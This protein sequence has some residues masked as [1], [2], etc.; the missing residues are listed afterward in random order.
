MNETLPAL[1]EPQHRGPSGTGDYFNGYTA[2]QMRAYA[3]AAIAAAH[4]QAEYIIGAFERGADPADY[5]RDIAEFRSAHAQQPAPLTDAYDAVCA[6]IVGRYIVEQRRGGGFWPYC[7][8]AVGGTMELFIG[9]KTKCEEV[10]A[11]LQ[12]ACLDGAFMMKQAGIP[13]PTTDT[14]EGQR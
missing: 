10:A 6:Q 14:G 11:A 9:H 2:D 5:W 8:R 13:A 1:P 3:R 4:A 7:V 12:T